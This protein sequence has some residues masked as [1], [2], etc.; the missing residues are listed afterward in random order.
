MADAPAMPACRRRPGR[1]PERDRRSAAN[2]PIVEN[3]QM[4]DKN[5]PLARPSCFW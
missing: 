3:R 2:M 5:M 4:H 1:E